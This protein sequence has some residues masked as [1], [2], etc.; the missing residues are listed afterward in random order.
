MEGPDRALLPDNAW[1]Y[2]WNL[3]TLLHGKPWELQSGGNFFSFS[4]P[5]PCFSP[6]LTTEALQEPTVPLE[7]APPPG[8]WD[9]L[10]KL[11]L[12][13]VHELTLVC[14]CSNTV[15]DE[16]PLFFPHPFP[17]SCPP[18]PPPPLSAP[19]LLSYLK[20]SGCLSGVPPPSGSWECSQGALAWHCVHDIMKTILRCRAKV[21]G[22][23]GCD[24]H[25]Q[26]HPLYSCQ[27]QPQP[28]HGVTILVTPA[29]HPRHSASFTNTQSP[30][31]HNFMN[32]WWLDDVVNG[33]GRWGGG[34]KDR[35]CNKSP[36]WRWCC[37]PVAL[38][39]SIEESLHKRWPWDRPPEGSQGMTWQGCAKRPLKSLVGQF[40]TWSRA[41][42]PK[43]QV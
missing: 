23:Y 36:S 35:G 22:N 2:C 38:W 12:G 25:L 28:L 33:R 41:Q 27:L 1:V 21:W 10:D 14:C 39:Q 32:M 13:F 19:F 30:P 15:N 34:E 8:N 20:L 7:T 16:L 11:C 5:A 17:L 37:V 40:Y 6:P 42:K 43:W 4:F 26:T 29:P 24:S 3:L 31:L 18:P 9:V